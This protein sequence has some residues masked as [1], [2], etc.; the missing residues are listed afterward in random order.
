VSAPALSTPLR[1]PT[2]D[3]ALRN[4]ARTE[5]PVRGPLTYTLWDDLRAKKQAQ[6]HLNTIERMLLSFIEREGG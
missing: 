1:N 4:V 3:T 2:A 6:R 5:R